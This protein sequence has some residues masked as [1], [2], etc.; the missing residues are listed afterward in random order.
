M[1][2]DE[3]FELAK[4]RVEDL[5]GFYQHL[6]SFVMVNVI[7]FAINIVISPGRLWFYWVLL[8]WGIGLFSHGISVFGFNGI[9][10]RDWEER[11][12]KEYMEK[13]ERKEKNGG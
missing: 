5:K 11:K 1:Q 7:L 4:K 12:I 13:M 10:G 3:K 6:L 2:K 9:L 8:F